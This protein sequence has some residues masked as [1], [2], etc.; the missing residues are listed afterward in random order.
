MTN[1]KYVLALL[2]SCCLCG[3]C[4]YQRPSGT[5]EC[6]A[7]MPICSYAKDLSLPPGPPADTGAILT[8]AIYIL[9]FLLPFDFN[10]NF[11]HICNGSN[12]PDGLI[13]RCVSMHLIL[14]VAGSVI[15]RIG[16]TSIVADCFKCF[17]RHCLSDSV[18][19]VNIANIVN[20]VMISLENFETPIQKCK[21]RLAWL[22]C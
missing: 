18:N 11:V 20:T 10:F 2:F 9:F 21:K 8:Q 19:T 17:N 6:Q 13:F 14:V 4:V 5:S 15:K 3:M 1:I 12:F 16:I 7:I 22:A